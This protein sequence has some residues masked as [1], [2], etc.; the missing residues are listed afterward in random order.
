MYFRGPAWKGTE[1]AEIAHQ[2][3]SHVRAEMKVAGDLA[4]T[5]SVIR[6]AD[7]V[8]HGSTSRASVPVDCS[9]YIGNIHL[10]GY[11][12]GGAIAIAV[13]QQIRAEFPN[14]RIPVMALFDAV[15]RE[16]HYGDL[17]TIP[18]NVVIAYHARRNRIV[19][20]RFYFG[21][22]GTAAEPPCKLVQ[23]TFVTTHGG[24][25]GVPWNGPPPISAIDERLMIHGYPSQI[26]ATAY[27]IASGQ[28]YATAVDYWTGRRSAADPVTDAL[29]VGSPSFNSQTE[30]Q[31]SQLVHKWMWANLRKHGIVR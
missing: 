11:S 20:S 21:N 30:K 27:E 16:W 26:L 22:C 17:Q 8:L 15:D 29:L 6:E 18:G 31:Q 13:A 25:G 10:A 24:M 2:C 7:V 1:C 28:I 23:L 14:V 3:M 4:S 12:R 19:G 9:S 5:D